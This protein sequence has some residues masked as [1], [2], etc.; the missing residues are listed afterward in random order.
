MPS[1]RIDVHG[2]IEPTSRLTCLLLIGQTQSDSTS[3]FSQVPENRVYH[4][5]SNLADEARSHLSPLAEGSPGDLLA[6]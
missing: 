1:I 6:I 3:P 5:R 2:F 4:A